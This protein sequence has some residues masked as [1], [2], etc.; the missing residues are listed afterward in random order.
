[1]KNRLEELEDKLKYA[2]EELE[3][4]MSQGDVNGDSSAG[5]LGSQIG[6]P[7]A[8]K[9]DKDHEDEEADEELIDEKIDEHEEE[10][11]SA[12]G[13]KKEHDKIKDMKKSEELIKYHANG[14]WSL[15]K[16]D[17]SGKKLHEEM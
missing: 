16:A 2:K 13:H 12:K 17:G 9:A 15:E 11:H 7:G 10:K 14:Q 6:W 3:K 5:S 1:M 8:E 4:M